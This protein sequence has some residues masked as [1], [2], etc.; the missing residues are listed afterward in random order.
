MGRLKD[1]L[2]AL[3][4]R[5]L[6]YRK[7][8]RLRAMHRSVLAPPPSSCNAGAAVELHTLT[9]HHHA[10]MYL[11][12][13]KSL[14]R[15]HRDVAVVVHDD[16]SL[17]DADK[18]NLRHHVQG[19][20]IIERAAADAQMAVLLADFPHSRRLRERV[21]NSFE[22]FDNILL[23][24][25]DR[26]VNMNSDVLFLGRPTELIDWI[27]RDDST[28]AGVYE[29]RPANQVDFLQR[30]G[31]PFPPHVTTALTC[32]PRRL[33]DFAFVEDVLARATPDWFTAQN[34][35]PLLFHRQEG[36]HVNRFFDQGRYQS[37]GVFPEGAAF[38]H[39][40]TSTGWFTD[41]QSSDSARVIA[42][43][44]APGA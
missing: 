35:Y 17:D 3:A 30:Y 15:H 9:A 40:W 24:K 13:I 27:E 38:R 29:E 19:I 42:E 43:L 37:S 6:R 26:I 39:Y 23:A 41:L 31:C 4:I 5:R 8:R 14:L 12:A 18:A 25:T 22:L 34:V 21:I 33:Y 11:T 44:A 28:I 16:G 32:L 10:S 36:Q 1:L 2:A 20:Q 7:K